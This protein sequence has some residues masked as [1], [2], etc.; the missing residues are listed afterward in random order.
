MFLLSVGWCLEGGGDE[1]VDDCGRDA[2]GVDHDSIRGDD[3]IGELRGPG[4]LEGN[5]EGG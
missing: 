5:E 2:D 1:V 3:R 4:V